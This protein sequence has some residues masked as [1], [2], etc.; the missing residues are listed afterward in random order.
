MSTTTAGRM[1]R[2][3]VSNLSAHVGRED[4]VIR[5]EGG[6]FQGVGLSLVRPKNRTSGGLEGE[7]WPRSTPN[8]QFA[9][10]SRL[11]R[12]RLVPE[13]S[14]RGWPS[15]RPTNLRHRSNR[16]P[17]PCRRGRRPARRRCVRR[18]RE[19]CHDL[20]DRSLY[21]F[22]SGAAAGSV[23]K[24]HVTLRS[25]CVKREKPDVAG[26]VATAAPATSDRGGANVRERRK[27]QQH[28]PVRGELSPAIAGERKPR[29][30]GRVDEPGQ[31]FTSAA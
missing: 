13:D 23:I 2:K 14:A 8:R 29:T 6:R 19:G 31:P 7:W 21:R 18:L 9:D 25:V 12:A 10:K 4:S 26:H 5:P 16:S 28:A 1:N 11:C 20:R 15:T 27:A 3:G 17:K 30:S 22:D 24:S